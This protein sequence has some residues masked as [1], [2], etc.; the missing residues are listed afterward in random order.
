MKEKVRFAPHNLDRLFD[1]LAP[2]QRPA[3]LGA[4]KLTA[5]L[6]N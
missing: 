2:L 4:S 6:V 1:L 5:A 3:R